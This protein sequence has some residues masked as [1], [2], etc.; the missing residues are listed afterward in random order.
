MQVL[1]K[2]EPVEAS[3]NVNLSQTEVDLITALVGQIDGANLM[4]LAPNLYNALDRIQTRSFRIPA[5]IGED[6]L[7]LER[8]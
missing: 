1:D 8:Q 2:V 7:V 3:Y 6:G 5:L 4:K